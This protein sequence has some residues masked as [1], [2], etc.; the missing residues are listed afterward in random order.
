MAELGNLQAV[1]LREVWPGEAADFTPWLA[2]NLSALG[3]ALGMDLELNQ[4]EAPVGPF[5]LDILAADVNSNRNVA[6]ENQLETTN[7]DHLGKLLTYASGY[8]ADIVIWIAKQ[9]RDEHRQALDWLNQRTD[10]TTEFYGVVVEAFRIDQSRPAFRFDVVAR[11]N[12]WRKTRVDAGDGGAI[13]VRGEAYRAYFQG[14]IDCLREQHR[15][16]NARVGRPRSWYSF[17]SGIRSISLGASYAQGG[18]VRAE[19]YLDPGTQEENKRL[20]DALH[21][22]ATEIEEALGEPLTWQRHDNA[23]ACR[24]CLYRTGSIDEPAALQE[25]QDWHVAKLLLLKQVLLP[26]LEDLVQGF[27]LTDV[28]DPVME[29]EAGAASGD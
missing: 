3:N 25:H 21:V 9:M 11:P 22:Q 13:S 28:E 27:T 10:T 16:T 15:F 5:A 24:I 29:A 17:D 8:N 1:E 23:R 18:R 6:I 2:T 7:H 20:F 19:V 4:I 12:Q 14:L 26:R